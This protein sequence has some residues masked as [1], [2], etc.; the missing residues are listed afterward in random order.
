MGLFKLFNKKVLSIDF[1]SSE[2]KII[3]GKMSKKDIKIFKSISVILPKNL[4][5][6]GTI[7]DKDTIVKLLREIL[8]E[9]KIST[10]LAYGIINNSSIITR[11]ISIPKV[12]EKEVGA[13]IGFQIEDFFPVDPENYVIDYLI[14]GTTIENDIEKLSIIVIGIPTNMVLDHLNLMKD[15]GLK[16]KVLDFQGNTMAKLLSCSERINEDYNTKDIVFAS[17]D[18]GHDSTKLTI[19]K[20]GNIEITRVVDI[21]AKAVYSNMLSFVNLPKDDIEEM[22]F[23]IKNINDEKEEL[24]DYNRM[25]SIVKSTIQGILEEIEMVFRYYRT[26]DMDNDINLILLQG[27]LSNIKGLDNLYSNFFNIPTVVLKS[28][29]RIN[30]DGELS[31]YSNSIGGLIRMDGM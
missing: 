7:L 9:N 16:P 24:T 10:E 15:V 13:I 1:G 23:K 30:W 28:L 27:G 2:I 21:G 6:N 31:K 19:I 14:I 22:M 25:I 12:D 4:Y 3:E 5:F 26:R 29:D 17:V 20:N 8:K 18:M 11:E